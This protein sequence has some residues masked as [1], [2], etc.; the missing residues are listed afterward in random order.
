M[1]LL[2]VFLEDRYLNLIESSIN[3]LSL[4]KYKVKFVLDEKYIE[5]LEEEPKSSNLPPKNYLI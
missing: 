3:Q 1:I 2:K 4:K 5:G